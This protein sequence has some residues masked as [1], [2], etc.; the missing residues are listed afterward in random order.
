MKVNVKKL[1]SLGLVVG[2]IALVIGIAFSNSELENAWEAL[3]SLF[4]ELEIR[5]ATDRIRAAMGFAP[6]KE[7]ETSRQMSLFDTPA[8]SDESEQQTLTPMATAKTTPHKYHLLTTADE[9]D[10]LCRKAVAAGLFCFDTETTSLETTDTDIVGFSV[11]MEEYEAYYVAMP[12]SHDE[13]AALLSHFAP[14]FGDEGVAKVGQNMKFDMEVLSAYG[15]EVRGRKFDT[16]IAHFL[17]HPGR[18]HS[19]DSMAEELLHYTPIHIE[20]LIGSG[21]RQTTMDTVALDQ[22][23]EYAAE[24]ADITLRLYKAL[25]PQIEANESISKIF[26]EIEMPLVDVLTDMELTGVCIDSK[27][28]GEF[29]E[30]LKREIEECG[31]RIR[32]LAGGIDFNISSP[33]QVGEVLFEKLK[34]DP[35]AKKTRSGSYATNEETLQKLAH[36][37]PV[38]AEILNYRGL[39]KLLNTY[40]EALPKMVSRKTGRLHTSYNQT[41]VVTGRLSSSNPNLQNIPVREESGKMIRRAFVASPGRAL[42]AADYSQVELRIMAHFSQDEHLL[43]AFRNGED[44]HRATAAKIYGVG[45]SDVTADMRRKAKTANFG[46]IYGISAFG[47]AE[48]L[49]IARK[50]AK[51][52]IDG[53]FDKFPG[54]KA[55]MDKCIADARETGVV[56]TLFGRVRELPDISS[57]NAVV[58]GMAERNAINAPIQGTAADI[59]KV[60]MVAIHEEL[61]RRG[62][63][64]KMILQ[65]HDE[66][67]LDTPDEEVGE[68]SEMLKEQM[69]K[70]C[71]LSVPLTAEVGTGHNWLEA[72]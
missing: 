55:Y 23:C 57:R 61:K 13:A 68:V 15:I 16:M 6:A 20:E 60:A 66:L 67:V 19:M 26:H 69:E 30:S 5:G 38:V 12:H 54:V 53:Y 44:I 52:L 46:I 58:R 34:I 11:A 4:A 63:K 27:A 51:D 43:N 65:V 36:A 24:D 35:N 3:E 17:L 42:V 14:A 32:S 33:K 71:T 18:K 64:A 7:K 39:L 8:D 72:H 9:V 45:D 2:S 48:R 50:E 47:L 31:E 56:R 25:R 59:I 41:V 40:A 10:E 49:D 28:L 29:A 22:I 62:L 21:A 37:H 1:L 70:A